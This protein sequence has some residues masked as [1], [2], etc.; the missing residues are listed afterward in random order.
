MNRVDHFFL[1]VFLDHRVGDNPQGVSDLTQGIGSLDEFCVHHGN[2]GLVEQSPVDSDEKSA[3]AHGVMRCDEIVVVVCQQKHVG[4][5]NVDARGLHFDGKGEVDIRE[6]P[7][8]HL[9]LQIEYPQGGHVG[10]GVILGEILHRD[11]GLQ[12]G[13]MVEDGLGIGKFQLAKE[14]RQV[15]HV[16][17][18]G[19]LQRCESAKFKA[20]Q[21][22]MEIGV[23]LSDAAKSFVLLGMGGQ[24]EVN[25]VVDAGLLDADTEGLV[26]IK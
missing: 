18:A 11:A 8:F 15:N 20:R 17:V 22:L 12:G 14:K 19:F 6:V 2:V 13:R 21:P 25:Q 24:P 3:V 10:V 4:V 7:Y 9:V 1:H 16:L 23:G 5:G 26:F